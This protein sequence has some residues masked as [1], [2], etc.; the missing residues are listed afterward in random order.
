MSVRLHTVRDKA[1]HLC[2]CP[3]ELNKADGLTK[4]VGLRALLNIYSTPRDPDMDDDDGDVDDYDESGVCS[5]V[6]M[7]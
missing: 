6:W 3:T 1:Q 2:Y 4:G 7:I 5:F